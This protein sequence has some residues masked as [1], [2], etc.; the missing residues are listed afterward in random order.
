MLSRYIFSIMSQLFQTCYMY[1]SLS[2]VTCSS[3]NF[4]QMLFAQVSD[5]CN[6]Q[7]SQFQTCYMYR[8]Q[9]HVTFSGFSFRPMLLSFQTR[10]GGLITFHGIG[11]LVCYPILNLHK[12]KVYIHIVYIHT[13]LHSLRLYIHTYII[14]Y[15]IHTYITYIHT[16]THTHAQTHIHHIWMYYKYTRK[17]YM[18]II[19]S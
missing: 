17:Y 7:W 6:L 14:I 1:R 9:T 15:Y 19:I 18:Y 4:R 10:R 2:H 11:Q 12:L 8:S 16:Y 13:Y 5:P 3:F